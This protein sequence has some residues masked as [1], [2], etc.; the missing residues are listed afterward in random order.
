MNYRR[1]TNLPPLKKNENLIQR[2][3]IRS[4]TDE[5]REL[6]SVSSIKSEGELEANWAFS[7]IP[8]FQRRVGVD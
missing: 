3:G 6:V 8:V 4:E 5:S 7:P 1:E 2:E